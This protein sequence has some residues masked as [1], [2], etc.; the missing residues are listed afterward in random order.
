VSAGSIVVDL[1][2]RTGSFVTDA[3]RAEKS[4][5]RLKAEAYATGAK[6]GDSVNSI[7]GLAGITLTVGGI[8]TAF[9][10]AARSAADFA[11]IA[12]TTG[13]AAQDI[14]ALSVAAATA[15]V[16]I[17]AVGMSLQRMTKSL[18]GVDDESKAA[19]AALKALGIDVE[20]FKQLDP[21]AQYAA[22]AKAMNSFA[23]DGTSGAAKGSAAMAI[24]G[25][26]GAEQL[27]VFKALEEQGGATVILTQRQIEQA[28]EFFDRYSRNVQ[29]IKLTAA[30]Y[31]AEMLPALG[32]VI[33]VGAEVVRALFGI[34]Q[35]ASALSKSVAIQRWAEDQARSLGVLAGKMESLT[36][37]AKAVAGS[38][39]PRWAGGDPVGGWRNYFDFD[40]DK[41]RKQ[42]GAMQE[43]RKLA[44]IQSDPT[45][46]ARRGR[47]IAAAPQL[48]F[49]GAVTPPK[50]G[51]RKVETINDERR[52][53]ASYVDGLQSQI[54][55]TEELSEVQKA[56]N[57]LMSQGAAGQIP[58][59]RELVLG[60]AQQADA[61]R[62]IK[63][64]EED[65]AALRKLEAA[66]MRDLDAELDRLS[67]RADDRRKIALTDRLEKML[68]S[69]IKF[70]DDELN[71]M[72]RGIAGIAN[73]T[74]KA[75]S[76][77]DELGMTFSSAFEDAIVNGC[78]LSDV[79]NG[80]EKD[81]L[82]LIT[83][84]LV[85]KPIAE[86]ITGMLKGA[87]GG[88]GGGFG[89]AIASFFSSI[90]GGGRAS[91]GPVGAGG[92]YEVNERGQPEMLRMDGRDFLLMGSRR[93]W[94]DP[95]QSAGRTGSST[96][97]PVFNMSFAPGTSVATATQAGAA[98][99]RRIQAAAQRNG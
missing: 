52:A 99:A 66:S 88:G 81:I 78:K 12:E 54:V 64:E 25:K 68:E 38:F 30:A 20:K 80:L 8:A 73:E 7:A 41:Y 72:V 1:L 26:S 65:I 3:G 9:T 13:A 53:L 24:M 51:G 71:K 4:L 50:G 98:V 31:A 35:G 21:A 97:S 16:P 77:A 79:I 45:E 91:G 90:F 86:S 76:L 34:E 55:K 22:L 46:L 89:S 94:V 23:D 58:Q 85:T 87:M 59:V 40:E 67:G 75:K 43:A 57:F 62:D 69:G 42:I 6:I 48:S 74:E 36:L 63:A 95:N 93:G 83:R 27:K 56:L 49:A 70:S 61:L 2:M 5:K 29:V 17:D 19:G 33:N 60:L 39:V 96:W 14:A 47:P 84:E 82:R 10:A 28:D 15:G 37:L 92:L 32:D 11:D 44:E 18:T